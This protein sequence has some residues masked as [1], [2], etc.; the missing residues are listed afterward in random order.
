MRRVEREIGRGGWIG[1]L[2][3]GEGREIAADGSAP[4]AHAGNEDE[5][6]EEECGRGRPHDSRRG[7]RRYKCGFAVQLYAARWRWCEERLRR[8]RRRKVVGVGLRVDGRWSL[9]GRLRLRQ[10]DGR[11][12]FIG[13]GTVGGKRR[14]LGGF[15]EGRFV[16][17]EEA[18]EIGGGDGAMR[19]SVVLGVVEDMGADDRQARLWAW[20][21]GRRDSSRRRAHC[22]REPARNAPRE[23]GWRDRAGSARVPDAAR[24]RPDF[25]RWRR[26]RRRRRLQSRLPTRPAWGWF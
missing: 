24:S 26:E 9:R 6:G 18:L 14:E 25:C 4:G 22:R 2:D 3:G 8:G 1:G 23:R 13:I 15:V 5:G 17:V 11:G 7:R 16:G 19:L 21:R 12:A 10:H 20:Q